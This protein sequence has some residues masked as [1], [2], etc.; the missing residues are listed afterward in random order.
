MAFT[1]IPQQYA[2]LG[3]ALPYTAE[4]GSDA[5]VTLSLA[6]AATGERIAARRRAGVETLT[7]D[8]APA[9]RRRVRF[10]PSSG[11]TGMKPS[12][13]RLAGVVA[14]ARVEAGTGDPVVSKAEKRLFLPAVRVV[15]APA[16]LTSMPRERLIA[17]GE[18]D[19]L[20]LFTDAACTVT[21][22]ARNGAGEASRTFPSEE[23]GLR[24]FRL[25]T[26]DFPGAE[27]LIVDTGACGEVAYTLVPSA[28]GCRVAW[29]SREGS[30]EHYTFPVEKS[31]ELR[32]AKSRVYGSE[33]YET[34]GCDEERRRT[35][36]SAFEPRAVV[37]ALAEL[38]SSP[39]VWFADAG[40]YAPA[41]VVTEKV[42][43]R[44]C[45]AMSALEF[46]IRPKRKPLRPWY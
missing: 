42:V 41:D 37:E 7:L 39:E 15:G 11:S 10:V 8:A 32:T 24:L 4:G 2:P 26:A 35:L 31:E 9:L 20:T 17:P 12:D 38:A 22:T 33:G 3:G 28:G 18:C 46:E 29:R 36:V 5:T 43:V 1:R 30:I 44:R 19:E 34:A 25:D 23:A 6:D 14:E 16:L 40:G 21:V 45:G 27:R 13:D